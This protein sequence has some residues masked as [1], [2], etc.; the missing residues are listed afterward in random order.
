MI[1]IYY[2][3]GRA[4]RDAG[5]LDAYRASMRENART[6]AVIDNVISEHFDGIRLDPDTVKNVLFN[7]DPD[8]VALVLANTLRWRAFDGRFSQA[9]RTWA[10]SIRLPD[11]DPDALSDTSSIYACNTHSAVLEGFITRFRRSLEEVKA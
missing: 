10:A 1:P 8:R 7:A 3:S 11:A 2:H 6:R 4:A 9:S 5:E